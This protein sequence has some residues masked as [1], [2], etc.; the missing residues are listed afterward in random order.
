MFDMSCTYGTTVFS[1]LHNDAFD[2]WNAI[3]SSDPKDPRLV[4]VMEDKHGIA[5]VGD[6]YFIQ[7]NG[8]LSP[9]WDS[10][11]TGPFRGNPSA[12]VIAQKVQGIPSPDGPE[13]VDWVELKKL[14]GGLATRIFRDETVK[15]QPPP[16]VSTSLNLC[17]S[18][19]INFIFCLVV[20]PWQ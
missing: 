9:I 12:F 7:Q 2:D 20:H 1:T 17:L 19:L 5:L 16:T 10:R 18:Y 13:N 11:S 4:Q 6:Y 15:G 8:T 3:P 14:S